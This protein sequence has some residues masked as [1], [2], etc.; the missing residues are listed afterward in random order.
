VLRRLPVC[1]ILSLAATAAWAAEPVESHVAD[2]P[3]SVA[4]DP[5][6]DAFARSYEHETAGRYEQAI[7]ALEPVRE[8]SQ[9]S[10]LLN[11]RLGWLHYL[12]G[13]YESAGGY[14]RAAIAA[15]LTATEP[16]VGYLLPL[17]AQLR[18]DE[19]ERVARRVL[20][21]D[22]ANYYANLRLAYALRKQNRLAEAEQIA[23]HILERQPTD[24]SVLAELGSV[25]ADQRRHEEARQVFEKV[26]LLAPTNALAREQLGLPALEAAP[27]QPSAPEN[28]CYPLTASVTP[29]YAYLDYGSQ[30]IKSYGNTWG[31]YGRLAALNSLEAAYEYTNL[32]FRDGFNLDQHD[33]TM[34]FSYLRRP[35]LKLR[36]GGHAIDTTDVFTDGAWTLLAGA[37]YYVTNVWDVGVDTYFTRYEDHPVNQSIVQI[38]PHVGIQQV[39]P[40]GAT[41]RLDVRGHYINTDEE[42][43]G[44]G[45][46]DFY[47]LEARLGWSCNRLGLALTAWTGE[48]AF[49]VRQD[50][51]VI[52]NLAERHD[53]GYGGEIAFRLRENSI[54][55]ARIADEQSTDIVNG[56]GTHQL[57]STV[58]WTQTF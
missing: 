44:L 7:A 47:S 18:F 10:Y 6:R 37:H 58:L 54:L 17:L 8:V 50:G 30:S 15:A 32:Q 38:T 56:A 27:S 49:A 36:V 29:Y 22:P 13:D 20:E 33:M 16:R 46:E 55:T 42:V 45:T 14:Y 23:S 9:Q 35:N 21:V 11:L 40:R 26:L 4:S 57:V 39:T 2:A 24:V 19:A 43:G 48:Q 31:V 53:G 5:I 51:F 3:A 1:V 25:Y 52:Y 28:V 12:R 41:V 34:V